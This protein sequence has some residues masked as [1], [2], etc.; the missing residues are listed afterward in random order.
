MAVTL[1]FVLL[2]LDY[3]PLK[4]LEP[5]DQ[6]SAKGR[7]VPKPKRPIFRLLIEKL[8]FL[9][10]SAMSCGITFIAQREGGAVVT[11]ETFP[12]AARIGNTAVSYVKYIVKS[13]VPSRLAFFYP[14]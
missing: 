5:R 2:L 6:A 10:L 3:W 1:P 7:K 13:F 4:R 8:P 12:L 11:T 9:L 14:H